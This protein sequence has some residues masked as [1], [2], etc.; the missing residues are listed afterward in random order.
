MRGSPKD[1]GTFEEWWA[2]RDKYKISYTSTGFNQ[3]EYRNGVDTRMTGNVKWPPQTE[4]MVER[5]LIHPLPAPDAS[6]TRKLDG[7]DTKLG[8]VHL[9]C[10]RYLY[11]IGSTS[12]VDSMTYPAFCFGKE[13]PAIRLESS[14]GNVLK[15]F[16]K[17]V[18][19]D[20]QYLAERVRIVENRRPVLNIDVTALEPLAG[21]ESGEFAAPS[22]ST[23]A[24]PRKIALGANVMAENRLGGAAPRYPIVAKAD[25]IQGTVI[26]EATITTEGT[27]GKLQVLKGPALLQQGALDAVK[28]WLYKPYLLNGEPV[29]VETQINVTFTLGR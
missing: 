11:A 1:Q 9:Q 14:Y 23:P 10:L 12:S 7:S 18:R 22:G 17:V 4:S 13:L 29:E 19:F 21:V 3:V 26:L 25:A 15:F 5:Y 16:N 2:G 28:T 6:D 20:G 27:I 8:D 24:P